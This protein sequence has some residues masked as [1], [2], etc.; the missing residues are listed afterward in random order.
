MSGFLRRVVSTYEEINGNGDLAGPPRPKH[1]QEIVSYNDFTTTGFAC[2]QAPNGA[3]RPARI[4]DYVFKSGI[5]SRKT[6]NKYF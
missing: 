4:S 2:G 6:F 3:P 5:G 1:T